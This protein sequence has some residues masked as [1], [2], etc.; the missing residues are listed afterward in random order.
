VEFYN[1]REDVSLLYAFV[2]QGPILVPVSLKPCGKREEITISKAIA[3]FKT[4][5]MACILRYF[6]LS[7]GIFFFVLVLRIPLL[8]VFIGIVFRDRP[9]F[10]GIM[11]Q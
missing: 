3:P 6:I 7:Y 1:F 8:M 9:S 11:M 4:I 10:S 5:S 2:G